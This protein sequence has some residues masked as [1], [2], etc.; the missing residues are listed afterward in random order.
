MF[1]VFCSQFVTLDCLLLTFGSFSFSDSRCSSSSVD[2]VLVLLSDDDQGR[3]GRDV[4]RQT[5]PD[6]GG[7]NIERSVADS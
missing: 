7:S 2:V 5:V 1:G 4:I 6:S 3:S